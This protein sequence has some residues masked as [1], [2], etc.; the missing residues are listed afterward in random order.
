M[1]GP[2]LALTLVLAACAHAPMNPDDGPGAGAAPPVAAAQATPEEVMYR[3][4]AG[5]VLGTEG[6]L[7]GAANEYLAAAMEATDPEIARRATQIALSAQTWQH[8]AMAADRWV[9]LQPD[10]LEAREVAARTLLMVGDYVGAEHQLEG[11]LGLLAPDS[12]QAWSA[13]AGLLVSAANPEKAQRL[14]ERLVALHGADGHPDALLARSRL[15]AGA[16]DLDRAESLALQAVAADPQRADTLAWAGRLAVNSGDEDRALERYRSAWQLQPGEPDIAMP[17]AELLRRTGDL[18]AAQGVLAGLADTPRARLTRIVFALESGQ[19]ALAESLYHEFRDVTYPDRSEQAFQAGQAAELLGFPEQAI[20]WYAAV[21]DGERVV[22]ALLRR[23][24]L[25]ART[26]ELEASRALLAEARVGGDP[27]VV[28]ESYLAEAQIM[29]D[30]DQPGEAYAIL[31]E[32]LARARGDDTQ[33]RYNRALLAVQLDRAQAAEDDLRHIIARQPRNAM[34][35]NAL[36]YTLADRNERLEEAQRL[37]EA[38]Y[39]LDPDEAS[40]IDSMG[41]VAYRLG[42]LEEARQYLQEALRREPNPEIAAHL[43]EVLWVLGDHEAATAV[44]DEGLELEPDNAV[45]LDT[46]ARF[47]VAR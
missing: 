7:E 13:I 26:G 35:L 42:R 43:G 8:A 27:T 12:R 19:Q 28:T 33:I 20:A 5:E 41:W 23:A 32:A 46:L 25:L 38:A 37:I 1:H 9:V 6:D 29:A 44:W 31:T 10:S 3:I 24:F 16:G 40:I 14:L 34:A 47:G 2:L 30:A 36:G 18:D 15:A 22:V 17:F 39:A 21:E 4:F 11:I 45:L